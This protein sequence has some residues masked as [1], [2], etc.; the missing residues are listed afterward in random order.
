MTHG[1][2]TSSTSLP[3]AAKSRRVRRAELREGCSA[4]PHAT[5]VD[6]FDFAGVDAFCL[7]TQDELQCHTFGERLPELIA[8]RSLDWDRLPPECDASGHV[9]YKWR[10]QLDHLERRV[11]HLATQMKWRLANG[12]GTAYYLVGVSDHGVARGLSRGEYAT[13]VEVLMASAAAIG[14]AIFVECVE[15]RPGGRLCAVWRVA[16]RIGLRWP[17]PLDPQAAAPER[18]LEAPARARSCEPELTSEPDR[19]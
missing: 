19:D 4:R 3:K 9:E 14:A 11:D 2:V 16:W 12:G 5:S 10:L 13:T 1:R 6:Q 8:S 15:R 17:T 7:P 18:C